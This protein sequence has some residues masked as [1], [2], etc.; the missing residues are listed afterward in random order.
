LYSDCEELS[1]L[2]AGA[3]LWLGGLEDSFEN[4]IMLA[5]SVLESGLALKKFEEICQAQGG[6]LSLL[7]RATTSHT[8]LSPQS[9]YIAKMDT[10][11]IGYASLLLGAGRM[12]SS[13]TIDPVAGIECLKK[14]GASVKKN[15]PLA[16][17]YG[18]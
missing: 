14:V 1:V 9:G 18:S 2:L 15:E 11:G 16:I 8:V 7:P 5:Q 4:G 13:D 10:E 6:N 17:L 3:M 12:K